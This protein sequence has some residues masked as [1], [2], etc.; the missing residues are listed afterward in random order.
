MIRDPYIGMPLMM[1]SKQI[2]CESCKNNRPMRQQ[3]MPSERQMNY[4]ADSEL[5]AGAAISC[6]PLGDN[7]QLDWQGG[8]AGNAMG[9][10][11]M[12]LGSLPLASAYVP[13]QQWK[14]T[15]SLE[16]GLS[17]GTIFPELD[18]PFEGYMRK[19]GMER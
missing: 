8:S 11:S 10:D 7:P 4:K 2:P 16:A 18:L 17:R 3:R 9:F 19:G 15:Y 5:G 12:Y 1:G 14:T 6:G 13:F